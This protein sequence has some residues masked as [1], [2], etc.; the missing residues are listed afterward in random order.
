MDTLVADKPNLQP[1]TVPVENVSIG[2]DSIAAKMAA[3]KEQTLRNQIGTTNATETGSTKP[4][5]KAA[6]VAPEGVDVDDDNTES[7]SEPEAVDPEA[8]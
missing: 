3:M 2:L 8:E 4:A 1:E 6:P 7:V 5:G